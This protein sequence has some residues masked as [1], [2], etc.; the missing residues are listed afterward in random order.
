MKSQKGFA[1]LA[2]LLI[3]VILAIIGGTGYY[4]WHSKNQAD[5]AY[6]KTANQSVKTIKTPTSRSLVESANAVKTTFLKLPANLQETVITQDQ[7]QAPE[8][9]SSGKLMDTSGRVYNPNVTFAPIGAAIVP[10]GCDGALVGLF[11]VDKDG[12]WQYVESTQTNF[13]CEGIATNPIPRKLLQLGAPSTDCV[14]ND[15]TGTSRTYD[16]NENKYFF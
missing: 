9:L 8:C 2:G 6:D 11:A 13:S 14:V 5:S 10:I 7:S 3:I 12:H 1:A 16:E 15:S 4:V